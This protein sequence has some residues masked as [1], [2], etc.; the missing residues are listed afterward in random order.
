MRSST[1]R[2]FQSLPKRFEQLC[3]VLPPRPVHDDVELENT[4]EIIDAMVGHD[5]NEDQRDYLEVLCELVKA[6]EDKH[7]SRDLSHVTPLR[8]LRYLAAEH[9]MT[10]SALGQ[11]LGNRALGSKLLQGK[12][13]LSKAHIRVLAERFKVSPALFLD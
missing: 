3:G 1:R 7:H 4:A 10:A 8:A 9:G 12:R 6:Y 13:E 5:L 11:L 2:S